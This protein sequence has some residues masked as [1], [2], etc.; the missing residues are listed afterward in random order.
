MKLQKL[1]AVITITYSLLINI[2]AYPKPI[3][4]L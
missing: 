4:I 3:F 2:L 1:S